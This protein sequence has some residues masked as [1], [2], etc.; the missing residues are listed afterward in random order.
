MKDLLSR[1]LDVNFITRLGSGKCGT[2]NVQSHEIFRK[3]NWDAVFHMADSP[4]VSVKTNQVVHRGDEDEWDDGYHSLNFINDTQLLCQRSPSI[5]LQLT[6]VINNFWKRMFKKKVQPPK[7]MTFAELAKTINKYK[8]WCTDELT[9][10]NSTVE[11]LPSWK[12]TS[13]DAVACEI[14]NNRTNNILPN[15]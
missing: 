12:Y 4:P 11:H 8:D 1:L 9:M 15:N 6:G 14:N 3:I 13:K 5:T 2:W 7:H 10:T